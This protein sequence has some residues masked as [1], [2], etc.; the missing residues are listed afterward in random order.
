[1]RMIIWGAGE[2]GGRVAH[3]WQGDVLALTRTTTRHDDL[4]RENVTPLV[5]DPLSLMREDDLLVLSLPGHALQHEAVTALRK[6]R[7]VPQRA[8]LISSTGIYG[9]ATGIINEETPADSAERAQAISRL[10]NDFLDWMGDRGVVFRCGG[11]Y[12]ER[13]GPFFAFQRKKILPDKPANRPLPLVHDEDVARSIRV[14]LIRPNPSPIYLVVTPPAP[15]RREFYST[16]CQ[17]LGWADPIFANNDPYPPTEYDV[18]KLRRELL[19]EP[20]H[21]DWRE[22]LL[23]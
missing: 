18:T 11:L 3:L 20:I 21:P 15:T 7:V 22:G 23:R 17:T 19:P 2:V 14:A 13:R 16:V 8:V 6:N 1:M 10:E 4:R 12:S 5:G 9:D